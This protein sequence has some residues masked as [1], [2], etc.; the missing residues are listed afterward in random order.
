MKGL[1]FII[2]MND[3]VCPKSSQKFL[4]QATPKPFWK[5]IKENA[6]IFGLLNLVWFIF[7]TGKKPT[8]YVYPCQQAALNNVSISASTL[9]TSLSMSVILV[10]IRKFTVF[11]KFLALGVLVLSPITTAVIFQASASTLEVNLPVNPQLVDK[12][13]CKMI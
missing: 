6:V 5:R 3:Q 13:L 8:R 7:R 4:E 11:G 2:V 1:V 12:F 10:N 9:V